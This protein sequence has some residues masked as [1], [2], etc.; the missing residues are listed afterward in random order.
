MKTIFFLFSVLSTK[1]KSQIVCSPAKYKD[2]AIGRLNK[3]EDGEACGPETCIKPCEI[4]RYK[5][6]MSS[7]KFPSYLGAIK[8]SE[9]YPGVFTKKT[10]GNSDSSG[11]K[12]GE[13]GGENSEG[14]AG[15]AVS[16][17]ATQAYWK[18][19]NLLFFEN[20]LSARKRAIRTAGLQK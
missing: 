13:S 14:G 10:D 3:I 1:P 17:K 8:L 2:C 4:S 18:G 15:E 12:D 6:S 16:A 19:R 5:S 7:V 9:E 20:C 11:P